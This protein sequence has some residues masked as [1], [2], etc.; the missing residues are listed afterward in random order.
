M[1]QPP[2]QRLEVH[3]SVLENDQEPILPKP[4]PHRSPSV[5]T[6]APRE[7]VDVPQAVYG[8]VNLKKYA[9]FK[10]TRSSIKLHNQEAVALQQLAPWLQS[11]DVKAN[12]MNLELIADIAS[13]CESFF[14]YGDRKARIKSIDSCVMECI[15]P[16][17]KDD[18]EVARAL[19]K[20]VSHKITRSTKMSRRVTKIRNFFCTLGEILFF[21]SVKA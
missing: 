18:T 20:S 2:A 4:A 12:Q 5:T 19:L 9:S 16:Y 14:I 10:A 3:P 17:C 15:T 7:V 11:V 21:N 8:G 6:D 13:F 1:A